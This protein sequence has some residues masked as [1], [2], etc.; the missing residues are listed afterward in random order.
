M[1]LVLVASAPA[2]LRDEP[3]RI[4]E[5]ILALG[6]PDFAVR[7]KASRD[8]VALGSRAIPLL[9]EAFEKSPDAEVRLRA[10]RALVDIPIEAEM[11]LVTAGE[12]EAGE[13]RPEALNPRR[14]AS[15]GAYWIDRYEVTNAQ[16]AT[17]LEATGYTSA[18]V[19]LRAGSLPRG[20]A[21]FPVTP[22]SWEDARAYAAWCGKRL[23]TELEWEK[24]GR[25]TDGR[26]YPWGSE[27]SATRANV[28]SDGPARIGSHPEDV[29]P[30]GCFDL[31]G[32]V[33]EWVL[34]DPILTSADE[35]IAR[36]GSYAS[37]GSARYAELAFRY[38]RTDLPARP[39]APCGF[40]CARDARPD[41]VSPR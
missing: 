16:F 27:W 6:S 18:R 4:R 37:K 29:S 11:V 19:F 39:L 2:Q 12:F 34:P 20:S 21:N 15:T 40:R 25:G 23:P 5:A 24:A 41:E 8:V 26:A 22:V 33:S 10:E 32:N 3:E 9:R 14:R 28:Q 13:D 7:V 17:F 1:L 35:V 31:C 36:G 38:L 30:Y